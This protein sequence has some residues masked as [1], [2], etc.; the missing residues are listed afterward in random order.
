MPKKVVGKTYYTKKGQPYK[1][2]PSG[3]AMFIKKKAAKKKKGGSVSVGGSVRV[4][5]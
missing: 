3:K 5:G 4:G 1:I 2:L